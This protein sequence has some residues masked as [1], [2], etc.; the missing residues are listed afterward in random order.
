M[1]DF[2]ASNEFVWLGGTTTNALELKPS[3]NQ[4]VTSSTAAIII[5]TK[6][7]QSYLD[8]GFI[9]DH[10]THPTDGNI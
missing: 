3:S 2:D 5:A 6:H 8:K 7:V 4:Y 9:V 1:A 10:M